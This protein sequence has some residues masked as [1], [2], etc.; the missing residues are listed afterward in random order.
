[1]APLMCMLE[2]RGVYPGYAW[3]AARSAVP[4]DTN[5][6]TSMGPLWGSLDE[7]PGRPTQQTAE[8]GPCTV[9]GWAHIH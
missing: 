6:S 9:Q 1:M 3:R 8:G 2:V 4:S 5:T 7:N